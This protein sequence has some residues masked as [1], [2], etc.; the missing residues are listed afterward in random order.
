MSVE[1]VCDHCGDT[2]DRDDP[3]EELRCLAGH[4]GG[5]PW[6]HDPSPERCASFCPAHSVACSECGKHHAPGAECSD[7]LDDM[8][9]WDLREIVREERVQ[10]ADALREGL[11]ECERLRDQLAQEIADHLATSCALGTADRAGAALTAER[12]A[13]RAELATRAEITQTWREMH[14][15][16]TDALAATVGIV[17]AW[18][19]RVT[20]LRAALERVLNGNGNMADCEIADEALAADDNAASSARSTE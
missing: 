4:G 20:A 3:S 7:G 12:D 11:A 10:L 15:S 16:A 5:C 19:A 9:E 14:A 17:A 18:N 8:D 1:P 13:L 2:L 6:S